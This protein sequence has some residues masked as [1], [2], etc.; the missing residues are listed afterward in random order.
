MPD[1]A[2]GLWPAF[3]LLGNNF[4]PVDWPFCG[5]IDIVE[6]GSAA[7][8]AEGLQQEKLNSAIHFSDAGEE[9]AFDASWIDAPVDLSLDYHLYKVEW[10]P[11]AMTFYLDG[12]SFAS[13][14]I[15]P[16]Y[17][18]EFHE[19]AF[20]IINIAIGGW[21]YV[22]INDPGLITATFPA[23]M[24]VDWIRLEDNAF[25][26]IV[27]GADT[28]ETGNFGVYTETVPVNNSLTYGTD[29]ELLVW[30]NMTATTT[31]A[32]EGS[33]AWSFD[34]APG[35]WFGMG[36]WT[37]THRN[38]TNYSDGYLHFHIKTTSNRGHESR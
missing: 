34:I 25:T 20:P 32:Y 29:A 16:A 23:K 35:D 22:Q 7:G 10:T 28:E 19:P 26:E 14:D 37:N 38:M 9:Y 17:L 21:N 13:W 6:M 18:S 5:E 4:G 31:T 33:D 1:T 3:W 8:I 24:Y 12:V 2:D 15:T 30:N 36:V 27:L 11:T